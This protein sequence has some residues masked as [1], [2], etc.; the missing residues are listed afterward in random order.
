MNHRTPKGNIVRLLAGLV[1]GGI[2]LVSP[3][4]EGYAAAAGIVR[5][6]PAPVP[7][8]TGAASA[9]GAVR[10]MASPVPQNMGSVLQM[11]ALAPSLPSSV[12]PSTPGRE[13]DVPLPLPAAPAVP[14]AQASAVP[15]LPSGRTE[16]STVQDTPAVVE[17]AVPAGAE[18]VQG[19]ALAMSGSR[20]LNAARKAAGAL[21]AG[22]VDT[23]QLPD[24]GESP[25][26]GSAAGLNPAAP[27]RRSLTAEQAAR[28]GTEPGQTVHRVLIAGSF[29]S[30]LRKMEEAKQNDASEYFIAGLAAAKHLEGEPARE[31]WGRLRQAADKHLTDKPELMR[32]LGLT[33]IDS[34]YEAEGTRALTTYLDA[35]LDQVWLTGSY[36]DSP[37]GDLLLKL[38]DR[39][40]FDLVARA[41]GSI[42][43][44]LD[45]LR[46]QYHERVRQD[47]AAYRGKFTPKGR[48]VLERFIRERERKG[49]TITSEG[50]LQEILSLRA[51][52]LYAFRDQDAEKLTWVIESRHLKV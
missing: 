18:P 48:K 34:G 20:A 14:L 9:A 4:M 47:F 3:G 10:S 2:V 38:V 40:Q 7:G 8:L 13:T 52:G 1:C 21:P 16:P 37:L 46:T 36:S 25:A 26:P 15:S 50:F 19:T 30:Y 28:L 17:G 41:H 51:R 6:G 44:K 27:R 29:L 33:L 12:I 22:P 24:A 32:D 39:R 5:T 43:A 11:G 31:L 49:E 42:S 23:L 35:A 45:Q